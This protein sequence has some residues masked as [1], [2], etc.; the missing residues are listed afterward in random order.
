MKKIITILTLTLISLIIVSTETFAGENIIKKEMFTIS[1]EKDSQIITISGEENIRRFQQS[2]GEEYD[3]NLVTVIRT[4]K[5]SDY[6]TSPEI[7]TLFIFREYYIKNKKTSSYTDFRNVLKT[8]KRPAGKVSISEGVEI[9]TTFTADA[10]ISK[11]LLEAKL[12]FS[13]SSKK[14]FK[15][16]WSG[17]YS[18]PVTIK[19]YPIYQRITGEVWDKDVKY[20]DYIGKFSVKRPL[21]DDVRVYKR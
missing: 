9:A 19:V 18:Y 14:T 7:S 13:V 3:P 5:K 15:I 8:Y 1:D 2:L 21:G 17:N 10:G 6:N 16:S 12:G 4:I 11:N 20:D